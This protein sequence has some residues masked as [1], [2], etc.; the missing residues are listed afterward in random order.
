MNVKH[1]LYPSVK[2][3]A[4]VTQRRMLLDSPLSFCKDGS[5]VKC[6]LVELTVNGSN[7]GSNLTLF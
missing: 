6:L 5:V 7:L 1:G 3:E 4:C 2:Y